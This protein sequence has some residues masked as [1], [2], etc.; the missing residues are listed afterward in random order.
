VS[1]PTL[2]SAQTALRKSSR[3]D[4]TP[5]RRPAPAVA[6]TAG[7]CISRGQP[8][9][10]P[11]RGWRLG[12]VGKFGVVACVQ[13]AAV[14]PGE[15][16]ADADLIHYT[17][18]ASEKDEEE[19]I[20]KAVDFSTTARR[21]LVRPTLRGALLGKENGTSQ[22]TLPVGAGRFGRTPHIAHSG[23]FLALRAPDCNGWPRRWASGQRRDWDPGRTCLLWP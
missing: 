14:T 11:K 5:K 6:T 13:E 19:A 22:S 20:R 21:R 16:L 17:R 8:E 1:H 7:G 18:G 15:L 12:G 4:A 3:S 2:G 9:I 23:A 10:R